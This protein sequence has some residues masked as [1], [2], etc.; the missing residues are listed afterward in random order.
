VGLKTGTLYVPGGGKE[1]MT[2]GKMLFFNKEHA[3]AAPPERTED[4]A[5]FDVWV[6]DRHAARAEAMDAEMKEA[7]LTTPVPGIADM[8]GQGR[9]YPCEPYGTCWEPNTGNGNSLL[10]GGPAQ[11]PAPKSA[12]A[13]GKP[14][15]ARANPQD[16]FPCLP[17][18]MS[19]GRPVMVMSTLDPSWWTLC[20]S[21]WWIHRNN[22]YVWVAGTKMHHHPPVHWIHFGKQVGFVPLHPR[23]VR[24][25][26]PVN[27]EHGFVTSKEKGGGYVLNPIRFGPEHPLEEMKAAPREFRNQP[28]PVLGRAEAPHMELHATRDF[29]VAR[30]GVAPTAGVPLRFDQRTGGFTAPHTVAMGGHNATVFAPVGHSGGYSGH[31]GGSFGGGSHGGGGGGSSGGGSHG[32]G[33]TSSVSSGGA[34]SVGGSS[35]GVSSSSGASGGASGAGG[36]HH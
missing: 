35:G 5:E 21:G 7:G 13:S 4:F 17:G 27:R 18:T 20:H 2:P 19:N 28:S 3:Q 33:G 14:A 29:A 1:G 26:P 25:Q 12:S 6:A 22:R 23:D 15:G 31:S 10:A 9:F 8:K 30:A 11:T 32:G 36:G 16:S 24:G 34:I